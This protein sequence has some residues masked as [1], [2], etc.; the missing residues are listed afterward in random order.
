LHT[1][2]LTRPPLAPGAADALLFD[3]GRVVLDIDFNQT[4][5][6]WAGHAGC[7]PAGLAGRFSWRDEFYQRHETG[8]I[9][10][11]EFFAGLRASLGIGISDA[12]FLEGWNAIFAGEM[13]GI[14]PLLERA[15]KRLPLYAFSNTNGAHVDHFSAVYAD[16]L[17][18]FREIF[19]SSAIGLRKPDAAAYDHVVNAIGVPAG[20]IVFFD[21]LAENI[22]GARARGLA[23]VHVTS[24]NDVA[25]ALAALGI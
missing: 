15:A 12:Q 23:A 10:D 4:L 22:E 17:G 5:A 3:L 9:S 11:A 20:R 25:D 16:V 19:L 13:P 1:A 6:C 7:E 24:P 21:D 8:E 2:P 14:A 18:N